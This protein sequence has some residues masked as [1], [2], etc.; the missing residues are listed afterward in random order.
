MFVPTRSRPGIFA[1]LAVAALGW[2]SNAVAAAAPAARG[3]DTRYHEALVST[4]GIDLASPSGQALI[5]SLIEHAAR[6]VCGLFDEPISPLSSDYKDCHADAVADANR[7]LR[8]MVAR[9]TSRTQVAS[10][11]PAAAH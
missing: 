7:Q 11:R 5:A 9:A 8:I 10:T 3:N 4:R 6:Q 2:A 1:C